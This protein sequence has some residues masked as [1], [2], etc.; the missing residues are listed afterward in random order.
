MCPAV[1]PAG[2]RL[3][4]I[5]CDAISILCQCKAICTLL[6]LAQD[7]SQ[8]QNDTLQLQVEINTV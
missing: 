1:L 2:E 5:L 7:H 6:P 8:S 4:Y 3:Q